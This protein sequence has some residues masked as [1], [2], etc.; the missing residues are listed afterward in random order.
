MK[1][2]SRR[3]SK[4]ARATCPPKQ[5]IIALIILIFSSSCWSASHHPQDFLNSIAGS[6]KQGQS[7]VQ[8]YCAVCHAVKPMIQV[9][10]PRIDN[11]SDWKPR[12][13]KGI[14][15]LFKHTN[16]GLNAMPARG[17]CFECSDQQLMLAIIAMLP[18]Q[19]KADK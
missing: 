11:T 4:G 5:M 9:G 17:G 10:A 3:V 1:Y 18:N 13:K 2:R 19:Y 16:E 12:M 15:Q 7:I 8:H 14:Q 6:K